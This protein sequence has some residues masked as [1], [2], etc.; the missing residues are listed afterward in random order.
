MSA[1]SF[2]WRGV[3]IAF[4][5]GE[6]VAAALMRAGQRDLGT[7]GAGCRLRY[8]CGIGACQN[9]LVRVDGTIVEACLTPASAGLSVEAAEAAHG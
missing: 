6:S 3:P 9:C 5:S 7:D 8:F 1:G 4:R 2:T